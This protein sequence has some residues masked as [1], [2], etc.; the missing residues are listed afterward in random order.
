MNT[1]GRSAGTTQGLKLLRVELISDSS[2]R[3]RHPLID[4]HRRV[5]YGVDTEGGGHF[6]CHVISKSP[7]SDESH[8]RL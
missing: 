8:P 3:E 7:S 1:V 5:G 4:P 6:L 2:I